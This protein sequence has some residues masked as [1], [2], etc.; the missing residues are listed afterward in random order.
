M[1]IRVILASAS[2]RR[3]ELLALALDDFDVI[4]ANLEEIVPPELPV[5]EGPAYLALQKA[6]TLAVKYPDALIIGCDTGVIIDGQM[7]GKPAD[8]EDAR[9]MLTLLSAR[10]HTVITG[11]CLCFQGKERVF[12]EETDVEFYPLRHGEI[13]SYIETGEPF[14][15]AGGYGIQGKGALLIRGIRGD[16]YNVMGLPVA[17]LVREI[18]EFLTSG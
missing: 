18:G 17:R 8:E 14:D 16:Y 3:K 15:K 6:R 12:Q 5:S 4:A 13:R 2:P 9:R 1:G 7:L 11:C 10:I